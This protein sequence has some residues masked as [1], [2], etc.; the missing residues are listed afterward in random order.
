MEGEDPLLNKVPEDNEAEV[1]GVPL[2]DPE[3]VATRGNWASED[4]QGSLGFPDPSP[5]EVPWVPRG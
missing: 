2:E 3:P 5:S 1:V 4:R